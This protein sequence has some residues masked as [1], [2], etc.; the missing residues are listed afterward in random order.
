M[1]TCYDNNHARKARLQYHP[2]LVR[3]LSEGGCIIVHIVHQHGEICLAVMFRVGCAHSHC[4]PCPFFIVQRSSQRH[5]P[6]VTMDREHVS[7][8]H[9]QV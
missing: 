8:I 2:H 3:V 1:A 5:P 7:A 4:V 6:S 9:V